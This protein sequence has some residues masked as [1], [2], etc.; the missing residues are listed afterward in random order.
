VSAGD[1]GGA[2][3]SPAPA[4]ETVDV[5]PATIAAI[6]GTA[7][8]LSMVIALARSAQR[9]LTW[10]VIGSLLALALD[11]VVRS[12]ERRLAIRRS[13][14]LA[15]VI[16]LVVAA[17]NLAV[18]A[19]GPRAISEARSFTRDIPGVVERLGELPVVGER[20]RR[21]DASE[22]VADWLERLPGR[23]SDD[24]EPLVSVTRSVLGG[25]LAAFVTVLVSVALLL[26]GRRLRALARRLVPPG[27][28]AGFDRV[29]RVIYA[30]V[31]RYFAGTLLLATATGVALFVGGLVIGVPL[32]PM[33][34]LWA[35]VTNLIPQ[36]GGFLGGSVFVLLAL[37]K[38]PGTALAAL[39][40]FLVW[41]QLEN[42]VLHP[43]IV[44][45]AVNLSPPATMLAA[46]VG[47]ATAGIP[48]ALVAVPLLGVLKS[49]A[50]EI[51][52]DLAGPARRERRPVWQRVRDRLARPHGRVGG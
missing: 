35:A 14:A 8:A 24:P 51:R 17:A 6:V 29:V 21:A 3:T 26:D 2:G 43:T 41:Q 48:G 16:V 50:L 10:I 5:H 30:T 31:G 4:G 22:K 9:T 49:V 27:H 11:P 15:T 46:L 32:T 20:L 45:D 40:F 19:L 36:V 25:A 1:D 37:T 42:H 47:G 44:G 23:L 39:V 52:P 7:F 13:I 12:I 33:V 34:A 28:R 18:V 38:S